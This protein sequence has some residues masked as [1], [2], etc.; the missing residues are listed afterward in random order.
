MRIPTD[1]LVLIADGR[2]ML[3][4]RNEG[5]AAEPSLKL[6]QGEERPNPPDREQKSDRAGQRPAVGTGGTGGMS[7]TS[8]VDFH[9]Q[10]EDEFARGMA[11]YLNARAL[12]NDLPQIVIA[13]PARVLGVLRKNYHQQTRAQIIA[14]VEK[15][16]T[17]HPTSRIASML[18]E[19][20][21]AV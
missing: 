21:A 5:S 3:L 17:G 1:S 10:A 4:Y 12:K 15:D 7:S 19:R 14:E 8:E 11:D 9:Q 16:L 13:A 20:E 18:S 6:V 2:K